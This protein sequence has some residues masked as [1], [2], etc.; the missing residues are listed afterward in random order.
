MVDLNDNRKLNPILRAPPESE[1]LVKKLVDG[2]SPAQKVSLMAD[3]RERS[4]EIKKMDEPAFRAW[5]AENHRHNVS[6]INQ[7]TPTERTMQ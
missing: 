5:L 6:T 4:E 2:M 7:Q 3:L 1:A